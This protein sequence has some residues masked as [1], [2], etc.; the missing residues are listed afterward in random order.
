MLNQTNLQHNNNKYYLGQIVEDDVGGSY[1][2]WFRWGRVGK[3]AQSSLVPCESQSHAL[4][5]FKSKFHAK[6]GH[7]WDN[8]IPFSKLEGL[9]DLIEQDFGVCSFSRCKPHDWNLI[10][11]SP[12]Q[13]TE[14]DKNDVEENEKL[15]PEVESKLPAQVFVSLN[16]L[17]R[18]FKNC[19]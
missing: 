13:E 19:G 8:R 4:N 12:T 6:T 17:L 15:K 5:I 3:T 7:D 18:C 10:I 14:D 16:F 11:W 1:A 2:V 9:Y